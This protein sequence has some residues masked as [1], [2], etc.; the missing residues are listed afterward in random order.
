[1]T[2]KE[3][4]IQRALGTLPLWMRIEL[5]DVKLIEKPGWSAQVAGITY[6]GGWSYYYYR[7]DIP[8]ARARTIRHLID[9]CKL[10]GW[11]DD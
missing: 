9:D 7:K 6:N 1:M 2:K 4:E 10:N 3:I 11:K 8:G 5:G